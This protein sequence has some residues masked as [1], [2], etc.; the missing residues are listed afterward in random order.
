MRKE[1]SG[2]RSGTGS[3]GGSVGLPPVPSGGS[4]RQRRQIESAKR[5]QG[6]LSPDANPVGK[7]TDEQVSEGLHPITQRRD[8][9]C[10]PGQ[11]I[12]HGPPYLTERHRQEQPD[13]G[14]REAKG[15]HKKRAAHEGRP[16]L[17]AANPS[18]CPLCGDGRLNPGLQGNGRGTER[19]RSGQTMDIGLQPSVT[20]IGVGAVHGKRAS[21][22]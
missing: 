15:D 12:D 1:G 5:Q 19:K 11:R 16:R 21:S 22:G 13:G 6:Q 17:E 20:M 14:A 18:R 9:G 4:S 8:P 7:G 10:D 3:T 2:G